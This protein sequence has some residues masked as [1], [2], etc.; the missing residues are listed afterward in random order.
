MG[1]AIENVLPFREDFMPEGRLSLSLCWLKSLVWLG[2]AQ[3]RNVGCDTDLWAQMEPLVQ[4]YKTAV[5][6]AQQ[7]Q[8]TVFVIR[9]TLCRIYWGEPTLQVDEGVEACHAQGF[10]IGMETNGTRNVLML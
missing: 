4:K 2:I 5:E 10:E 9:C 6:L 7:F 1:Y 8:S 3:L